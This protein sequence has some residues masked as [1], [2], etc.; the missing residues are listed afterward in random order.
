MNEGVLDRFQTSSRRRC[1]LFRPTEYNVR[2]LAS[3]CSVTAEKTPSVS[4]L[5]RV[6]Y[7]HRSLIGGNA[8]H[9]AW[10]KDAT[11]STSAFMASSGPTAS[12][13]LDVQVRAGHCVW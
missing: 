3:T 9:A 6:Y 5:A 11:L 10:V 2:V 1:D 4:L 8:A 12:Y 7:S 13:G